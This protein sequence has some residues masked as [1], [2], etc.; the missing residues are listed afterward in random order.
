MADKFEELKL[1]SFGYNYVNIDDCW[2]TAR[3]AQGNLVRETS[4]TSGFL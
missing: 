1:K 4:S 3:D 2:C